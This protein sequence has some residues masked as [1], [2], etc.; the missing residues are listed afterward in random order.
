MKNYAFTFLLVLCAACSPKESGEKPAAPEKT[1]KQ[2][3]V[4]TRTKKP[5]AAA[6]ES[7]SE[8]TFVTWDGKCTNLVFQTDHDKLLSKDKRT[9]DELQKEID[10]APD[11]ADAWFALAKCYWDRYGEVSNAAACFQTARE[12]APDALAPHLYLAEVEVA[13]LNIEEA[14]KMLRAAYA[15]AKDDKDKKRYANVVT[16]HG[17]KYLEKGFSPQWAIELLKEITDDTPYAYE[18]LADLYLRQNR[19]DDALPWIKAG[20]GATT[21]IDLQSSLLRKFRSVKGRRQDDEE[22]EQSYKQAVED[23]A[24]PEFDKLI[25]EIGS[26]NYYER[27][28][29]YPSLCRRAAALATNT[30]QRFKALQRLADTY[31]DNDQPDKLKEVIGEMLGTN[32]PSA[33][34]ADRIAGWFR[35]VSETNE[36]EQALKAAVATETNEQKIASMML[37][38]ASPGKDID[39]D[40][41]K[42]LIGRFPS[43]ANVLVKIANLFSSKEWYDREIE[44][45]EKALA[46]MTDP[47][48]QA[49][50]VVLLV[51]RRMKFD[52]LDEAEEL[53]STYSN[54]LSNNA[55]LALT[56]SRLYCAKGETNDAFEL[57]IEQCRNAK[58]ERDRARLVKRLLTVRWPHQSQRARARQT[59]QVKS[60]RPSRSTF[61]RIADR[62]YTRC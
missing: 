25:V 13:R 27:E 24:L 8:K 7:S 42:E 1:R 10:A 35:Q 47:E 18:G 17:N 12:L 58:Y 33:D 19:K 53:V 11:N 4:V 44:C 38:L 52:E 21:N 16:A 46:L 62:T 49:R 36:A 37:S 9:P 54:V 40:V 31:A 30:A 22:F 34:N 50:Q 56:L 51:K 23:A 32:A 3:K 15:F 26:L 29:K 20:L 60:L 5:K 2:A 61:G 41:I 57:L 55:N 59:P 6:R 43:N 39:E 45:R 14:A 48:E 28:A